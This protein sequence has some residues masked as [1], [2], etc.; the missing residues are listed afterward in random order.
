M[1]KIALSIALFTAILFIG[2]PSFSQEYKNIQMVFVKGGSFFQGSDDHRYLTAEFDNEKPYH[3]ISLS[4]FYIGKF[5]FTLG[6]YRSLMGIRPI[7]YQ[8][9]DYGNKDC[10]NCPVVKLSW[11]E[12][13]ELIKRLNEKTGKHYRLPTEAEWEFAARGGKYSKNLD[14]PGSNKLA[15]VAWYGK[16]NGTTHPGGEKLPNELGI[17][18]MGG[19]VAEFCS[20]WYAAD[21]YSKTIDALDPKGPA[22]GDKKVIRGGSYLDDNIAC[23][24]VY[25]GYVKPNLRTWNYGFR[26]VLDSN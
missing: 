15:E 9:S 21:Y 26:L 2:R 20:D 17:F 23:R 1:N 3:R 11:D 13:M 7:P 25:R 12:V 8:G 4:S 10:D 6:Q 19:N 14:Y 16:S 22:T 5:E 18:D 24:P